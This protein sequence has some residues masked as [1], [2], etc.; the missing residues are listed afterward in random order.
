[1]PLQ[2]SWQSVQLWTGRSPVQFPALATFIFFVIGKE[3]KVSQSLLKLAAYRKS[4]C[5]WKYFR[6]FKFSPD[7][8][9]LAANMAH[10]RKQASKQEYM[11]LQAGKFMP[12]MEKLAGEL[13][14]PTNQQLF[15]TTEGSKNSW[16]Q[17]KKKFACQFFHARHKFFSL[18][19]TFSMLLALR[20]W[21]P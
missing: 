9:K 20:I 2:L 3:I 8:E 11:F 18:Q 13:F 5:T 16:F 15:L 6:K 21:P 1:M 10:D 14:F 4:S 12:G 17:G 19:D 7:L